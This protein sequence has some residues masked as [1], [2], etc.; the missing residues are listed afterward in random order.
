MKYIIN[1]FIDEYHADSS[2]NFFLGNAYTRITTAWLHGEWWSLTSNIIQ[3]QL[4]VNVTYTLLTW[5]CITRT[6]SMFSNVLS[7]L[8]SWKGKTFPGISRPRK[9]SNYTVTSA[10]CECINWVSEMIHSKWKLKNDT[11]SCQYLHNCRKFPI[12]LFPMRK[13]RS[14][15]VVM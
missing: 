11:Y 8:R 1:N 12:K 7:L 4:V 13:Y 10:C 3:V 14:V 9:Y 15:L 2:K 6:F 5:L